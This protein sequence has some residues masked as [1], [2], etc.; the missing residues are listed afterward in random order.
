MTVYIEETMNILS[1]QNVDLQA[2]FYRPTDAELKTTILYFHGGG[3]VFG[4][5]KD[6][7]QQYI[8]LL[9]SSGIGILA[10]DYP[11]APETKLATILKTTSEIMDWLINHFLPEFNQ[12]HYF[13]MGRSAGAFLALANGLYANHLDVQPLGI[14]SLYGYFN[15]NDASFSV[16][17]RHYLKYPKVNDQTVAAQ[18][19]KEPL[20][21]SENQNR[22]LLYLA[23]RQKG[24]W[25]N[26][27][28]SSSDQKRKFSLSKEDLKSLPSLFISAATGDPDIPVRQSR[29]LANFH[30][31]A[32]LKLFEV[33]EHD[34]DRTHAD[35]IGIELYENIVSWI[36]EKLAETE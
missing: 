28:L 4:S 12:E 34:F 30:P 31:D 14:I 1:F 24:D 21:E 8:E 7:P 9:A 16:P 29:Q 3:F 11:L 26:L 18:I 6:L 32:T 27:F 13:M 15:L 20:V 17:N 36:S 35:T 10:I 2:T 23:A 33:D 19:Q 25:L 5:R 22:Y